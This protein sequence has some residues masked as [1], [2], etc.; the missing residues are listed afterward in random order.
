MRDDQLK[1]LLIEDNPGDYRL[2]QRMLKD[3]GGLRFEL[4]LADRLDAGLALLTE[5]KFDLLLLDLGLPECSGLDT[6]R[7]VKVQTPTVPIVVLTGLDDEEMGTKAVREGA[8]DYLTKGQVTKSLLVRSIRY[9]IERWRIEEALHRS[10]ESLSLSEAK[11]R[12]IVEDMPVLVCRFK[13][14]GILTFVNKAYCQYFGK[15]S[16]ELLGR[17]FLDLIPSGD[18]EIVWKAFSS[19]NKS[20]PLV[21]YEHRVII[22][23]GGTRWQRWTDRVIFNDLGDTVEYQSVGEDITKRK[24]VEEALVESRKQLLDQYNTLK[25]I[26]ECTSSPIFSVDANYRYTSFNKGHAAVMKALYGAEVELG[27]SLLGYQ[28]VEEDR[29]KAKANIDRAL[30]GERFVE[31]AYSGEGAKSRLYFEVSHHPITDISGVVVG[32][33]VYARDI[34][35]RKLAEESLM[36]EKDLAEKYLDTAEVILVALDTQARIALINRKGYRVLGYDE[37]ELTG[38]NWIKTCLRP[39]DHHRVYEVNRKIIEGEIEAF[40]YYESYVLNKSGEERFIAWHTT[41]LRDKEGQI[42]GT[43]S[44]GE[45]ITERKKADEKLIESEDKFK[46]AFNSSPNILGIST[47]EEGRYLEINNN[48]EELLGWSREEVIGHTSK[49]LGIFI[50]YSKR[51]EM[52]ESIRRNGKISNYE[53]NIRTKLGEIRTAEFSAEVVEVGGQ[54]CMLAQ[55]NDITERKHMQDLLEERESKYRRLFENSPIGILSVDLNGRITEVND[56][57][58][59]VMG[60]PSAE[61]TKQINMFEF[62]LLVET[63][64]ADAF[65]RCMESGE[66]VSYEKPYLSKWGKPTY[67]RLRINPI[68]DARGIITGAQSTVEDI[69]EQKQAEEALK[70]SEMRYRTLA[71]SAQ[72]AIYIISP[73]MR[74]IYVNSFAAKMLGIEQEA[75]MGKPLNSLFPADSMEFMAQSLLSV[76]QT[77]KPILVESKITFC[78][79]VMWQ[80]TSLAPI[81]D[82]SGK[83][84]SILGVS[85]D[86]TERRLA[87]D[88]ILASLKEKEVLLKE[89]HHRVKNNLQIISSLLSIQSSYL[90]D[91]GT[92]SVLAECQNR[93]RSMALIHEN[94]YRSEN[95]ARVNFANY[96]R[97]LTKGLFQSYNVD[98]KR[99]RSNLNLEEIFLKVDQA[100][101]CGLILN[102]LV[103][104]CLKYAFPEGRTGEICI[105]LSSCNDIVVLI[106]KDN[107][108]GM[109]EVS[110]LEEKRSMGLKL[111][112]S[113]LKQLKGT[114]EMDLIIGTKFRITFT[115][116]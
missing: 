109:P 16:E 17:S 75:V 63:G 60:S 68:N 77:G 92:K 103:T 44:S 72:D 54:K 24:L 36:A 5:E 38:K 51:K 104:N 74:V 100:I 2:I 64:I 18:R 83:I 27:M 88:K 53:V 65:H 94:L 96:V 101:P 47:F 69:S 50:D 11:Y 61:A 99:I 8:Q 40:E 7:I 113:L 78:D 58:V 3:G 115:A 37:G 106:V 57:L 73:D 14:D 116:G 89:I 19:L 79:V 56:R 43:L 82:E 111:T 13:P 105:E 84:T 102:E 31:E 21:N 108:I 114:M 35:R 76:F 45:D 91:E 85:R 42:I 32:V 66:T 25:G 86:I 71:E 22:P 33:A 110:G 95:L 15:S 46:K 30:R 112:R 48:F 67:L 26:M 9:A 20:N 28:T 49:E 23:G 81:R 1:I 93:V 41:I 80:N 4:K 59:E 90:R 87:E 10:E 39:E 6:L 97:N 107:G 70:E 55:V 62:P 34:T 12:G 29:V 52:A 98:T